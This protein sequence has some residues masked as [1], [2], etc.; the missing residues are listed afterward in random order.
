MGATDKQPC[1]FSSVTSFLRYPAS[2]L[3]Q[4]PVHLGKEATRAPREGKRSED[5]KQG[6]RTE[7]NTANMNFLRSG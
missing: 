7:I 4:Q 6:Q 3:F 5:L 1:G 2:V